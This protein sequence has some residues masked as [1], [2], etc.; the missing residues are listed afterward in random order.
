MHPEHF[1]FI[2]FEF[3]CIFGDQ[4][5]NSRWCRKTLKTRETNY[6]IDWN[7]IFFGQKGLK[8]FLAIWDT[9]VNMPIIL[10][11]LQ[12]MIEERNLWV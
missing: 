9:L 2:N 5:G 10:A 12:Q 7:D 1:S 8:N 3:L 4:G 11:E 6:L